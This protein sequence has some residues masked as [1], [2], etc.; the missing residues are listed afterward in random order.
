MNNFDEATNRQ[1]AR[2]SAIEA[3]LGCA[4]WSFAEQ[5]LD[6]YIKELKDIT[7]LDPADPAVVQLLR[8]R[9]NTAAVLEDW[10]AGLKSQV[11]NGIIMTESTTE[12]TLIERR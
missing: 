9:I 3:M 7:S 4:G 2:A 6:E 5:D 8:D 11:N 10:L 12:T 1:L